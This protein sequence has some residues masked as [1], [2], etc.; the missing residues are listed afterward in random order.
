MTERSIKEIKYR[1]KISIN[2]I[3]IFAIVYLN[4]LE[5]VKIVYL[6]S[7]LMVRY[8]CATAEIVGDDQRTINRSISAHL[9]WAIFL[10]ETR[11]LDK[12]V[13]WF[14]VEDTSQNLIWYELENEFYFILTVEI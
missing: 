2:K 6:Y 7:I 4:L 9:K 8:N 5:R 1:I 10:K 12:I 3:W 14:E 13:W 11:I